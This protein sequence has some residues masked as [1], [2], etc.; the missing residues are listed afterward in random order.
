M[1]EDVMPLPATEAVSAR[2]D[3]LDAWD[4]PTILASLWEG[5]LAAVAALGP[6]LPALGRAVEAATARLAAGG[7][8]VYA[9]AGTSGR[10][11]V[12]DAVEL[13]PTF[14]WP[15]DRLV[16]LMAGGEAALL[17]SV[18]NAEDRAD[19]AAAAVADHALGVND[20]LVGVA[21]SGT[22][23]FTVAAVRTARARGALTIGI[24]NSA[25]TPLLDAAEFPVAIETGAEAI[26]GSTRMKAGTAQ[27]AALN[28]FSSA[29]MVRLGHVYRGQMVDMLARNAK[30]RARAVRMLRGITGC[31]E[32]EARVALEMAD[33]KV[34][35][36]ILIVRGMQPAE[37]VALL[38]RH[39]GNLRATLEQGATLA[40]LARRSSE[41][42]DMPPPR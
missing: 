11:A 9:G 28:L 25:R 26:A 4:V 37:A 1:M 8:L 22:T 20:V 31:A 33:G 13:V 7:R 19:L 5:Q 27:K 12:Q 34:K 30:L 35:V 2:H 10:I 3:M 23:R 29:V 40:T 17:R 36:A 32:A 21:A 15:E 18:E 38:A 14:D 41:D 16:L 39:A 42:A 24:A 6:A